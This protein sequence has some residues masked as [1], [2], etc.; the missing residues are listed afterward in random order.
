MAGGTVLDGTFAD[1]PSRQSSHI[2]QIRE[3]IT[4]SLLKE[5]YCYKYDIS[6]PIEKFYTCVMELRQRLGTDIIRCCGFGHV[7]DGNLHL[8]VTTKEYNKDVL[9]KIEPYVYEW[10]KEVSGSISSEHGLGF[11]KRNDM[12]FSKPVMAINLMHEIKTMFDPKNIL[13]PY[14]VLPDI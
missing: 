7:G 6:I 8:T 4:E 12:H 3:R 14:K 10:T 1:H 9:S 11:K 5:G 2:W 13:N